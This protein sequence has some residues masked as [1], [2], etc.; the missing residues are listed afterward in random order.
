MNCVEVKKNYAAKGF[1]ESDVPLQAVNGESLEI[2]P[3]QQ[4]CCSQAMEEKLKSLSQKDYSSRLDEAFKLLRTVFAS[5][6]R[7]FDQFFTELLDNA[8]EELHEMFVK[9]YGLLY[10]QN[11]QIF[12]DLFSDLRAYY[13]GKDRNL[14]DVMDTFFSRLLQR[15]FELLNGQYEFDDDYLTCVTERM[16]DLKPFGDVPGKLSTQIK[17]AFIAA[18]TFVQGLAIGRDVILSVMEIP[19]TEACVRGI[20]KMTHCPKCSGLTSTKPCNNFCLNTMKGCLAHHAEL[21]AVWN[22]YIDALKNLAKRLEG[23]F[24]IE[25]VVDPIDVKISGAIMNLQEN[26][27]QVSSKIFSGCGQP[28]FSRKKRKADNT[29]IYDFNFS[30]KPKPRPTTAAGTSLDRLV[31]DIKDKVKTAK[32]FWLQLPYA[33]CNDEDV[34]APPQSDDDCWNGQ[35]RARYV[36]AVQKDGVINQI[37]NPEVEVDVT[38]ASTLFTRQVIQLRL[39]TTRL[40]SAYNGED[41]DWIDT[42]IEGVSGSGSGDSLTSGSG[43][44]GRGVITR[45]RHRH[46]QLSPLRHP[47]PPPPPHPP[48]PR[49]GAAPLQPPP[50]GQQAPGGG[51]GRQRLSR[52]DSVADSGAGGRGVGAVAPTGVVVMVRGGRAGRAENGA[53]G[54]N[55]VWDPACVDSRPVEYRKGNVLPKCVDS[56]PVEYHKGNVLPK[57]VNS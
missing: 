45:R 31:R 23:P 25:S 18:R 26:S 6:T 48:S 37:N 46:R 15:M 52:A 22:E 47:P 43:S 7:K 20:M 3:Q 11:A 35:D 10:Q 39:I 38:K 56:R 51:G 13:K 16:S 34:A 36:P 55:G 21:N 5:K 24:N 44:G 57:C 12:A 1:A 28:R 4:S 32:D 41:V 40:N 42:E 49:W 8:R 27:A 53:R 29:N 54:R 50:R 33:V 2:C 30:S 9:T 14:V 17:R 19:P